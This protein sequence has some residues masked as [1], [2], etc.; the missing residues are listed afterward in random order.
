MAVVAGLL[1]EMRARLAP[2]LSDIGPVWYG[3]YAILHGLNPYETFGPGLAVNYDW[4]L[5]YPALSMVALIPL[6]LLPEPTAAILFASISVGLL[7]YGITRDSWDRIWIFVSASFVTAARVAQ[8]APLI[9]AAFFLPSLGFV[10][11]LKPTIGT[12]VVAA[13]PS[14]KTFLLAIVAAVFLTVVSFV[15]LPHW[16]ADWLHSIRTGPDM[17]APILRPAGFLLLLALLRWRQ[18]EGRLL[19]AM[20]LIPQTA[21]WYETLLPLLVARTKREMQVLVFGSGIGYLAQIVFLDKKH[22]IATTD[23]G[24][25]MVVFVYLPALAVVL[26]R[27]NE[28][29]PPAWL[30]RQR[31]MRT[32]PQA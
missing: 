5:N 30:P 26:R 24:I 21:S 16:P 8:W 27:P 11:S 20:A 4:P 12:A 29:P 18:P 9:G 15:V 7:A 3:G 19:L 13:T 32:A 17:S 10:L 22:E 14:R 31:S 28:G 1:V 23:I 6:S 2:G 25:L